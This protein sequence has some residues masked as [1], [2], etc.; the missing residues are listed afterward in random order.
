MCEELEYDWTE[1]MYTGYWVSEIED[2][3]F[4][5]ARGRGGFDEEPV[6]I[7]TRFIDPDSGK[8]WGFTY[9]ER[10]EEHSLE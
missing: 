10:D 7:M 4:W 1:L 3:Q 9:N 6:E 2:G 5:W 8:K